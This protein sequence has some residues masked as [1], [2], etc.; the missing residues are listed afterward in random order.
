MTLSAAVLVPVAVLLVMMSLPAS[1]LDSETC[2]SR[3]HQSV[4]VNVRQALSRAAA[5]NPR[6]VHSERDC[7]LACCSE[8]VQPGETGSWSDGHDP[9][10]TAK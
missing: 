3:Q 1:A 7:V 10:Q 8:D 6:L 2:F 9:I 5:M 4:T